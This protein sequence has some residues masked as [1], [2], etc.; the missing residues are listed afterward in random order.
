MAP[1]MSWGAYTW[2][3]GLIPRADGLVWTCQDLMPDGTH[4]ND[5]NGRQKEANLMM[6]FFK[7]DSTTVPW[8]LSTDPRQR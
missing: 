1:W 8:F 4:V 3:N 5:P 7:S 6:Q 2:A